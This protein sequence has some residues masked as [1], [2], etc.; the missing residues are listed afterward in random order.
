MS[1]A[2]NIQAQNSSESI[3]S[4]GRGSPELISS[5]QF[6]KLSYGKLAALPRYTAAESLLGWMGPTTPIV[7]QDAI[8]KLVDFRE[9]GQPFKVE[10]P[11][12]RTR[13]PMFNRLPA[14]TRGQRSHSADFG[15]RP[16]IHDVPNPFNRSNT[17]DH[18]D[19]YTSS[20]TAIFSQYYSVCHHS[21]KS[22]VTQPSFAPARY[23]YCTC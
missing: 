9:N 22:L 21:Y 1:Y 23:Q 13:L 18:L 12:M 11:R 17:G 19:M 15:L 3:K 20:S 10:L 4:T 6:H 16:K 2:R 14:D 7:A 8:R 5:S